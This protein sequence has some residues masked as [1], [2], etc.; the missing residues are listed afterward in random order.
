MADKPNKSPKK[1]KKSEVLSKEKKKEIIVVSDKCKNC[2]TSLLLDQRYCPNCGAKRIYNRLNTRN[3]LEDFSERFL[4]V[5]NAFL[6]TFFAL[7][8]KPED[9]INGYVNGLRKR[10]MSA[11]SYFAVALT[12][13]SIYLFLFRNWFIEESDFSSFLY[14]FDEGL[15]KGMDSPEMEFGNKIADV[16]FDY[17]SFFTFIFIPFYAIISKVVFWNYKKYNFIEHV[18]IFLYA[19]SQTQIVTNLL[20]ILFIWTSMGTLAISSMLSVFPFFYTAFVLYRVFDLT[21][22]KLLLKT[23]L[24]LA[25][26]L[27]FSCLLFSL[28]GGLL[29]VSGS[30]DSF[31]ETI[32]VNEEA[33]KA[34]RESAR[35]LKDSI[36]QD[37]I[38]KASSTVE[39]RLKHI[40]PQ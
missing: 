26:L 10:Y 30:L 7:F 11:F 27:P 39:D 31:I 5:E 3:L 18:V 28:G 8:I 13:G 35:V 23:L 25:V 38:R 32:K 17:Y 33:G 14:G 2:H 9:V 16:L 36:T 1:Q 22:E 20:L 37:S 6:R 29:Y 40:L 24:F 12:L 15:T 19:Y 21:L 34:A 4:N